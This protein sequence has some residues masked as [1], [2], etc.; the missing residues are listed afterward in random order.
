MLSLLLAYK[1]VVAD[2]QQQADTY[3]PHALDEAIS[4]LQHR[5]WE[6]EN[7]WADVLAEDYARL[8]ASKLRHP[9]HPDFK[10][11]I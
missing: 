2:L 4:K 6:I 8:E 3:E 10:G 5:I 7:V 9:S 1:E 11:F